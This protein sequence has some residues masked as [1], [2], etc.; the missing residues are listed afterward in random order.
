LAKHNRQAAVRLANWYYKISIDSKIEQTKTL[1]IMWLK[2]AIRLGDMKA[3]LLLSQFYYT[4]SNY[5]LAHQVLSQVPEGLAVQHFRLKKLQLAVKIAIALGDIDAVKHLLSRVNSDYLDNK[6]FQN[7]LKDLKNYQVIKLPLLEKVINDKN[8]T[9][10]SG[11]ENTCLTSV[12]LFAT[13][14]AHLSHI[15]NLIDNFYQEKLLSKYICFPK[16]RY[17]NTNMLNCNSK[18]EQAITCDEAVFTNI[19]D[20]TESKHI[21]LMMSKG[22]ANV[23]FGIL[24]F[25]Q[26]DNVDVFSHEISHL[27]GFV[28]EYPL[29][30]LHLTCQRIQ[31]KPF[32]HNI[33]V[34][35]SL[36]VGERLKIRA[37]VLSSIAWGGLIADSTPIL[38]NVSRNVDTLFDK[39]KMS[40]TWKVGTPD[41]H[42]NVLGIFPAET[43]NKAVIKKTSS[44]QKTTDF[45]AY[46]PLNEYTHLQYSSYDFSKHYENIL[47]VAPKAHLMP[48]FHYNIA[49]ALNQNYNIELKGKN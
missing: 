40:T 31:E 15:D 18:F 14:L 33:A 41:T 29:S 34:I 37:K 1:T 16:P 3:S 2:Q 38:Q 39:N 8:Y 27:L 44:T 12:Q 48:S 49:L 23:H 6:A 45:N 35:P 4:Q 11:N 28:D 13:T 43:C 42:Q 21:G 26:N 30:P 22:G 19:V 20:S 7:L 25:D 9:L 46:K 47:R 36:Y 17:I 24:Y 5:L 32:A 10:V